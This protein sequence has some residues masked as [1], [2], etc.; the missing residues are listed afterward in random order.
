ME[1]IV[2]DFQKL[3]LSNA[4]DNVMVFKSHSTLY[5]QRISCLLDHLE[6]YHQRVG[7]NHFITLINDT[8]EA[9]L[10]SI[11]GQDLLLHTATRSN[12]NQ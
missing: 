5:E 7:N 3:L 1:D 8:F 12:V 6:R 9:R 11:R 10:K 2:D 4:D